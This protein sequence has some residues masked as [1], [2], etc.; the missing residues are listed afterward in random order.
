MLLNTFLHLGIHVATLKRVC[1]MTKTDGYLYLV[2][3]FLVL[4]RAPSSLK[5]FPTF[6]ALDF[7]QLLDVLRKRLK[8]HI[9]IEQV[10]RGHLKTMSPQKWKIFEPPSPFVT[11]C[12][13]FLSPHS[14]SCHYPKSDKPFFQK[15]KYKKCILVLIW[16]FTLYT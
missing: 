6:L 5:N 2:G 13:Y 9:H 11:I 12:L 15:E 8:F 16:C 3:H 7:P 4:P 1:D 14:S 10:L